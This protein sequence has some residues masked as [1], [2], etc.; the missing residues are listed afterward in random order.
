MQFDIQE[1]N[2]EIKIACWDEDMASD[3]LICEGTIALSQV[4]VAGGTDGWHELQYG[5]EPAGRIHLITKWV[6][7]LSEGQKAEKAEKKA[8]I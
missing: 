8:Q 1:S 6:Q 3:D 2:D 5:G 4:C 7:P